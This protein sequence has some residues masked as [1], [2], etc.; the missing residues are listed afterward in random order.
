MNGDLRTV[1]SNTGYFTV[2]RIA[3]LAVMTA[4]VSVGRLVF[5]LP[6]LP[7]VQPMTALLILITL[8]IGTLD[9]LVVSVLSLLITNLI[10][11]SG[12]WTIMQMA[13]FALIIFITTLLK[14]FYSYGRLSN[15]LFFSLWAGAAGFLYGFLISYMSF[16]LYGLTNFWVYYMNGLPFD[17]LHAVGNSIFFFILEPIIVPVIRRKFHKE[18]I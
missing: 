18:T 13:S 7:N 15:R 9:G 1:S 2:N 3:L 6:V 5:A 11:G 17:I 16:Q 14:I 12:P 10:L 8:N 4:F